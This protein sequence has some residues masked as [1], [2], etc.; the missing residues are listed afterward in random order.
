MAADKD[1]TAMLKS[2]ARDIDSLTDHSSYISA[3]IG[4][5]LDSSLG[6]ITI[7]QNAIIKIFSIAAVVLLPSTLVASIYGMNFRFMP[8]LDWPLGYSMAICLMVLAALLPYLWFKRQGW[9]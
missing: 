2:M 7:E 4:F 6:M 1:T 8:E 9:L 3:N 5:L